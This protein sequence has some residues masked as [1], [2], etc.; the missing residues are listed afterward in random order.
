MKI[1]ELVK[2]RD[3]T[4]GKMSFP[5][6]LHSR[7]KVDRIVGNDVCQLAFLIIRKNIKKPYKIYVHKFFYLDCILF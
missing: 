5:Q 1:F 2:N 7:E 6:D 4:Y 3:I